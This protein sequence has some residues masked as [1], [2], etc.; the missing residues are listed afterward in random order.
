MYVRV[1]S[2]VEEAFSSREVI[3]V[4]LIMALSIMTLSIMTLLIMASQRS[5]CRFFI[6]K[7][8]P[9]KRG[10]ILSACLVDF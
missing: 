4:L 5:L 10:L 7:T 8:N 9:L 6:L 3:I 2:I 1:S